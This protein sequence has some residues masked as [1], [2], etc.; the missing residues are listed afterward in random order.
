M[1]SEL[2]LWYGMERGSDLS[3]FASF[4]DDEVEEQGEHDVIRAS[5]FG[6]LVIG[7][8][9]AAS[10]A[11]MAAS[12]L[13]LWSSVLAG[14][15]GGSLVAWGLFSSWAAATAEEPSGAALFTV[16]VTAG[17]GDLVVLTVIVGGI[18]AGIALIAAVASSGRR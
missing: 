10:V 5:V 13:P 18:V 15:A 6:T 3:E 7:I 17:I 1:A 9:I 2:P 12:D 11:G 16:M 8:I 4:E 14:L